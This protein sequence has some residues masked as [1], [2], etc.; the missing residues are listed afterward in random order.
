MSLAVAL[1]LALV[2]VGSARAGSPLGG[3]PASAPGKADPI[4]QRA[5][6]NAK[7]KYEV[8]KDGDF[9]IVYDLDGGRTQ[10]VWLRSAT[11][12]YGS[13]KIREVISYGY[14]A[15]GRELPGTVANRLLE[16]N[17]VVK[18]GAWVRQGGAALFVTKISATATAK[19]V[20]DALELT[21]QLADEM[22]KEF[23]GAKDEF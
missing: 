22:E 2:A 7:I 21:A 23:T 8:D 6:D 3:A 20:S 13:L 18:L 4:A 10:Q 9:R 16:H 1:A 14:K 5:L 11:N 15:A 12:D 17:N 19:E